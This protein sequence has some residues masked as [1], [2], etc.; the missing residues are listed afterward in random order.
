MTPYQNEIMKELDENKTSRKR[1][2]EKLNAEKNSF[3]ET[4]KNT[5][6]AEIKDVLSPENNVEPAKPKKEGALSKF[7]KKLANVCT[8][9]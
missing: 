3:A 2:E 6:G 7:F 1:E 9:Y 8:G 5:L 4:L